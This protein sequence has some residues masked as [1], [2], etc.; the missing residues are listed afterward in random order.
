MEDWD[1]YLVVYQGNTVTRIPGVI[2]DV[3]GTVVCNTVVKINVLCEDN[4]DDIRASV[5]KNHNAR[6]AQY[7]V[8]S[9]VILNIIKLVKREN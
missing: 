2:G 7:P 6:D 3:T 1:D 4:L 9:V 8:N 5:M